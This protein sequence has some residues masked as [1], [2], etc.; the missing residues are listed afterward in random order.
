MSL[1]I[2]STDETVAG[3]YELRVVASNNK[4]DEVIS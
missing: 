4:V 1:R 3:R 2:Y